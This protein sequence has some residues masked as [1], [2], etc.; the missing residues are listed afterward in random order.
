VKSLGLEIVARRG[1]GHALLHA[2][3]RPSGGR[4]A[5]VE[6]AMVDVAGLH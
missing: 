1:H 6:I 3:R 2:E 4:L 5:P